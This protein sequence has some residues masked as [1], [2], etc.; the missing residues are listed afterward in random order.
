METIPGV[1]AVSAA[2]NTPAEYINNE[3]PFR[4]SR[5]TED[6]NKE[7]SAVVGVVPDYFN[8]MNI[9][10]LEGEQFTPAM[11]NQNVTVLS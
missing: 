2:S 4:L 10:L 9:K 3:N 7:G 5:E 1:L 8:V 11:E 6:Q